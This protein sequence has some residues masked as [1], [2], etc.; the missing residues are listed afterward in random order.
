MVDVHAPGRRSLPIATLLA[1]VLVV[2]GFLLMGTSPWFLL[3]AAAGTF[4]PGALREMGWLRDRDEFQ[5]AAVRR[6]GYHAFLA[7]GAVAFVFVAYVRS[8]ARPLAHPEEL[9]T[10]LLAVLWFTWF[11]SM[12]LAT[13]GAAKG[14]SRLLFAFGSAWLVFAILS[15]VGD[16]WTGWTALLLH[17]LLALPFFALAWIAPRKPRFAGVLLLG[18]ALFFLMFFGA[19]AAGR[20]FTLDRFV[21]WILFV[22]P[23]LGGG[24]ALVAGSAEESE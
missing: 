18:F 13:W 22:G 19:F 1:A 17:P 6:A 10:V 12:L 21:T 16:E 2:L 14:T 20:P 3:L 5:L 23:L 15:N 9:A 7:T 11:L 24:L 8:N 4:G